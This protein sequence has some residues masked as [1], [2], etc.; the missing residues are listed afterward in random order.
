MTF[1]TRKASLGKREWMLVMKL[2]GSFTEGGQRWRLQGTTG[3]RG[4]GWEAPVMRMDTGTRGF[5][6]VFQGVE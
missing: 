4:D 2:R 5:S 3:G 6:D 1:V